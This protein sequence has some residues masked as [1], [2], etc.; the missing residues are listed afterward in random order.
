MRETATVQ[1]TCDQCGLPYTEKVTFKSGANIHVPSTDYC[2]D[3]LAAF[4]VKHVEAV[5]E[6]MAVNAA[7]KENR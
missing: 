6:R 5:S 4:R 2:V 7:R 3:C 1:V